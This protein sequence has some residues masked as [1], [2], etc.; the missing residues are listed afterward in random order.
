MIYFDDLKKE[1][2]TKEDTMF[3]VRFLFALD[4][5]DKRFVKVVVGNLDEICQVAEN[6]KQ[7]SLYASCELLYM[8]DI[9]NLMK[10]YILKEN[11]KTE[12][13]KNEKI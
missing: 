10:Y 5:E 3:A 4:E 12:E 11:K 7:E 6:I 13:N 8:V 1:L 9:K 2:E